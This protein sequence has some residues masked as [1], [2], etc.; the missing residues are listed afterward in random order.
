MTDQLWMW[1]LGDDTMITCCPLRWNPW[2][3]EPISRAPQ[4]SNAKPAQSGVIGRLINY[5]GGNQESGKASKRVNEWVDTTE[6]SR[7][8]KIDTSDSLNVTHVITNHLRKPNR[9]AIMSIYELA[10]LITSTCIEIFDPH[11]VRK[12]FRFFDFFDHSIRLASDKVAGYL[13]NFKYAVNVRIH[14]DEGE[15]DGNLGISDEKLSISNE[16]ELMIEVDDILD[17]LHTLKLVLTDQKNVVQD[18]NKALKKLAKDR[19]TRSYVNMRTLDDH[20]ARIDQME[21]TAKK[22]DKSA[23]LAEASFAQE[24]ARET[25][26]QSKTIMVFT[27]ITILFLPVS[28]I[29]AIFAIDT[30]GFPREEDDKIPFDYLMGYILSIGFAI[31]IPLII[32]AFNV[33][34]IAEGFN[35]F[36]SMLTVKWN[37]FVIAVVGLGLI[38]AVLAPTMV[39]S[40]TSSIKVAVAVVLVLLLTIGGISHLVYNL[41][42][43]AR[44]SMSVTSSSTSS[45]GTVY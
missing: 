39:S 34:R 29:A 17:E 18:M 11:H 22:A 27:V 14:D 36:R 32:A 8:P 19:T 31:S 25:A 12:E 20:L 43:Q 33:D 5:A 10:G 38:A 4:T 42:S 37:P 3:E 35:K 44:R 6:A 40:L 28:F 2:D 13:R 24:A 16:I 9:E 26:R 7:W 23:S 21:D 41:V 30:N 15:G 1:I 45:G